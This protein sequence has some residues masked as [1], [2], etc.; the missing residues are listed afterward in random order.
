MKKVLVDN[1]TILD[2]LDLITNLN[3]QI[4]IL[5]KALILMEI[6]FVVTAFIAFVLILG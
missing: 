6:Q 3:D 2:L 1:E 5:Y 4:N